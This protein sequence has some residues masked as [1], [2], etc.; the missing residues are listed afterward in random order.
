[1]SS[2]IVF[3]SAISI[4]GG[5]FLIAVVIYELRKTPKQEAQMIEREDKAMSKVAD[6]D[7]HEMARWVP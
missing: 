7:T 1:M 5:L 3:G 6:D 4:V 2:G